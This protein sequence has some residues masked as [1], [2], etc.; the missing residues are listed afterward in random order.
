MCML[1][2]DLATLCPDAAPRQEDRIAMVPDIGAAEDGTSG[3]KSRTATVAHPT[4]PTLKS[5]IEAIQG[6]DDNK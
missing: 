6:T 3:A 2:R 5:E 1:F 4:R